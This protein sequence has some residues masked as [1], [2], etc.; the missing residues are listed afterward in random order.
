[1]TGRW[2]GMALVLG[3]HAKG[4]TCR[5]RLTAVRVTSERAPLSKRSTHRGRSTTKR[6]MVHAA[7][8]GRPS[9][10]TVRRGE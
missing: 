8:P 4:A 6:P 7:P 10:W 2:A 1:M 9:G 5:L 3:E